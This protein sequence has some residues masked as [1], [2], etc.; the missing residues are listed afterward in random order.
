MELHLRNT[1]TIGYGV[2]NVICY[3]TMELHLS[4]TCTIGY[5]L[6]DYGATL[7]IQVYDFGAALE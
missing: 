4:N 5:L 1:C 6:A 3:P 7:E 2:R